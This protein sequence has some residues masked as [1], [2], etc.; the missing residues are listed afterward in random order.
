M[1]P[2]TRGDGTCSDKLDGAS[3]DGASLRR[4]QAVHLS[5]ET[6]EVRGHGTQDVVVPPGVATL[7]QSHVAVA[8]DM[9]RGDSWFRTKG[10]ATINI[11]P[12]P[13]EVGGIR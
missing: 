11:A 2:T 1:T 12:P 5:Y 4:W 7:A 10:T 9:L 8:K 3:L 6:S 13:A